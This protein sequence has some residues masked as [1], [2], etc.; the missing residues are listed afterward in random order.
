MNTNTGENYRQDDQDFQQ[1]QTNEMINHSF[2][3]NAEPDYGDDLLNEDSDNKEFQGDSEDN[4][5]FDSDNLDNEKLGNEDSQTEDF[6]RDQLQNDELG[7]EE[8]TNEGLDGK[9]DNDRPF[10]TG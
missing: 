7:N 9:D 8:L 4:Q 3:E 1:E 5:E 2:T 6:N 10:I